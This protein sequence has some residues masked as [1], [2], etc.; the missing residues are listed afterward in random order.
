MQDVGET[1]DSLAVALGEFGAKCGFQGEEYNIRLV[2]QFILCMRDRSTQTKLFQEPPT[3]LEEAVL[4]AR[5]FEAANSTI[6][7]LRAEATTNV[8]RY[9]QNRAPIGAVSSGQPTMTCFG[10]GGFGHMAKN[11]PSIVDLN[12]E[13][14]LRKPVL[15]VVNLGIL[16]VIV[17]MVAHV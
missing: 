3:T 13:V 11:C 9:T 14:M 12:A 7:S 4:I 10:C 8:A 16:P 5:R 1:F 6:A 2:D 15:F 17:F